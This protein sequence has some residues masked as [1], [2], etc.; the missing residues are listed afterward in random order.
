[1]LLTKDANFGGLKVLIH[2]FQEVG[3]TLPLHVHDQRS[4][5]ITVVARGRIKAFSHD[6]QKEASAGVV[7]N[8]REGEPH[9]IVAL[10]AN[11]RIVNVLRNTFDDLSM[12]K[13]VN[14]SVT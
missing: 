1:M 5:H 8:F 9:E 13:D 12:D 10:E 7:L 2:D 3:D 4:V 6:W 11:T 14:P